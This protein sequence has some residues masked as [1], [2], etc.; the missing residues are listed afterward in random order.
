MEF[1]TYQIQSTCSPLIKISHVVFSMLQRFPSPFV[2]ISPNAPYA[3]R[4]GMHKITSTV[5]L[6]SLKD[7]R[8]LV[9]AGLKV[10]LM[11]V[12]SIKDG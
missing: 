1:P 10:S 9:P 12:I 6:I 2:P 8:R 7:F 5:P 4:L 11:R 3:L